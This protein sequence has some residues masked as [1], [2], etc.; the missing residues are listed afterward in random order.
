MT[1]IP[2][3][4][5]TEKTIIHNVYAILQIWHN[6]STYSYIYTP[7]P[8]HGLMYIQ[9]D[10]A[11]FTCADGSVKSFSRGNIVYIPK[12]L[13]YKAAFKDKADPFN[14]LLINF[15]M[16]HA[17]DE[18]A[19]FFT[20][21]TCLEQNA[22]SAYIE[23]FY[24][25]INLCISNKNC[26]LSVMSSFYGLLDS[27]SAHLMKQNSSGDEYSIIAPALF[28]IDSHINEN[29]SVPA[30]AKMCLV[31]ETCFRK[32]FRAYAGMPPSRYMMTA[33]L[34]KAK[35]MLKTADIPIASIAPEL[36]FYDSSYFY[37][38]FVKTVGITPARY[39]ELHLNQ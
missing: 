1:V 9:C 13:R 34:E 23:E 19:V 22:S 24:R 15:S 39:R 26:C 17:G 18:N 31:S 6:T 32:K 8:N 2:I 10:K 16:N 11:I 29:I 33:K 27:I 4:D 3:T 38:T 21:I 30:L 20:D 36:G 28:Y 35:Q 7:R 25:I 37:K 5:I 14:T 12:G